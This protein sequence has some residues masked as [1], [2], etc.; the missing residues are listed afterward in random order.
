VAARGLRQAKSLSLGLVFNNLN[1]PS[2]LGMI[3]GIER[4][5]EPGGFTVLVT[6]SRGE[7]AR[8]KEAVRRLYDRRV[9]GV[10]LVAPGPL[11][12]SLEPFLRSNTP[13]LAL[14][15]SREPRQT[16]P[17]VTS[18]ERRAFSEA[19][20]H[21][22]GQGHCRIGHIAGGWEGPR[23]HLI[24]A[25][26]KSQAPDSSVL[27]VE[28][29]A[30]GQQVAAVLETLIGQTPGPTAIFVHLQYLEEALEWMKARQI[31]VPHDLS[32]VSVGDARWLALVDPALTAISLD[33]EEVGAYSARTMLAWL[34]G[35]RPRGEVFATR[36][37]LNLRRSTAPPG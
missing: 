4:T 30:P 35:Q 14:Q 34:D 17:L 22:L 5:C 16:L 10:F 15:S 11:G 19:V 1:T 25:A 13:V 26:L 31:R 27:Y 12:D 23:T 18:S 9:D 33:W 20:R 32:L 6:E 24:Q 3:K 8:Y 7:E 28:Q 36:A 21:L 2:Q 29:M 37:V